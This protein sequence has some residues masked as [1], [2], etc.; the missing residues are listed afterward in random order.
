MKKRVFAVLVCVM[1][2]MSVSALAVPESTTQDAASVTDVE[3][4]TGVAVDGNFV[5]EI[6][7]E[8]AY[9]TTELG[10]LA[11]FL[12][13]NEV[14]P[15]E[16]FAQSEEV[17]EEIID[18]VP[19]D[20]DIDTLSLYEFAPLSSANYASDYGN[21]IATMTFATKYQPEQTL[22][23]MV[24]IV[25]GVDEDGN[26]IVEWTA[27]KAEAIANESDPEQG[28]VQVYIPQALQLEIQSRDA[29]IAILSNNLPEPTA[30]TTTTETRAE[31]EVIQVVPSKT[32][33]DM[34][35]VVGL[36]TA[37]GAALGEDFIIE[38]I[39]EQ[40]YAKTELG[41]IAAFTQVNKVTPAGYFTQSET[42]QEQ[43]AELLPEGFDASTLM[44]YEFAPLTAINYDEEYGD[45]VATMVFA[46]K[47]R[48]EQT[49]VAMVGI[50]KGEDEEG[51]QIVEWTA[52]KA[53]AVDNEEDPEMGYVRI[54]FPQELV[55][56][57]ENDNAMIAI[58]S[59]EIV[60]EEIADADE[61]TD[62]E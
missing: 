16:Y 3:T 1:L 15:A 23:A 36:E 50:V 62:G 55:P 33:Q 20:F 52:L 31:E 39:E 47:Y 40:A 53:E 38:I 41:T 21:V 12:Q 32:T 60:E 10:V 34:A 37:T 14:A 17:R 26:Q 48:P 9:A 51:N 29:M 46:T 49:L 18:L 58:L 45:V 11:A 59:D 27:L 7:G 44:M 25:T 8:Q 43:I 24:G 54:Y 35:S 19:E 28:Y 22:V 61:V 4:S 6:T 13:K 5:I 42:I 56:E 2:C 57:I 30:E